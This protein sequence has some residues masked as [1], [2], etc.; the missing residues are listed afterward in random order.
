MGKANIFVQLKSF[1]TG[2]IL[3]HY[4]LRENQITP[5]SVVLPPNPEYGDFAF[6]C[7]NLAK[8]V[9]KSPAEIAQE[10][11]QVI[12]DPEW[13]TKANPMGPYVNFV[14]NRERFIHNLLEQILSEGTNFGSETPESDTSVMVEYSSPNT[15]KPQHLGHVRNNVLGMAV[16]N[17]LEKL[18]HKVIRTN[19]INDRGIHICKTMLAYQYWGEGNTPEPLGKKGDHFVGD[20]YVLFETRL[21]EDPQLIEE[22][23]GLLR[24]WE[25]G[26]AETLELWRTMNQWVYHGFD[27]T[28]KRLGCHFDK[29]YYESNIWQSGKKIVLDALDKGLCQRNHKGDTVINLEDKGLGEKVLLRADGTSIYIT[30]DIGTAVLKFDDFHMDNSLYVVA[31]EQDHH[32]NVLFEVLRRFGY[33]WADKCYH[34]SYG[35]V[36]LPEGKMKSREGTVVDAD[37]LMDELVELAKQEIKVR[38]RDITGRELEMVSEHVG[39]GAL[40]YYILKVNPQKDITFNPAESVSF[41]GATGPYLQYTHARVASL[42]RNAGFTPGEQ[43]VFDQLGNPEEMD[44]IQ[45]LAFFPETIRDSA[46]NYNPAVLCNYLYELAKAFNKFYHDHSILNVDNQ[47]LSYARTKLSQAVGIILKEGLRLLGIVAPERM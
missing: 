26:D 15:N 7:F 19:L 34:L 38:D 13:I 39:L 9:R 41:D 29:I 18:G 8:I 11:A 43:V 27:A 23:Q 16:G 17:I 42:M 40:K 4:N 47:S 45:K 25:Q 35:M 46:Q 14:I 21:K 22:A 31:S 6:G 32:F 28:Y 12:L 5:L 3:S 30:Q 44:I 1:T 10:L 24:K 20:L 37:N 2:K 36:Y 33:T